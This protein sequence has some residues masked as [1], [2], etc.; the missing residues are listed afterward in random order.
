MHYFRSYGHLK[1][2]RETN[3]EKCQKSTKT[4]QGC[5]FKTIWDIELK[6]GMWTSIGC[7]TTCEFFQP[8]PSRWPGNLWVIWYGMTP[9]W[10]GQFKRV[11][12]TAK[13]D[14][15]FLISIYTMFKQSCFGAFRIA[16]AIG[17]GCPVENFFLQNWKGSD[18]SCWWYS[19]SK[20]TKYKST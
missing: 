16:Y 9:K 13:W 5:N 6:F 15:L 10:V 7:M 18:W 1:E 11:C 17:S 8:N 12:M 19:Q 3:F 2:A 20:D 4:L 14:I